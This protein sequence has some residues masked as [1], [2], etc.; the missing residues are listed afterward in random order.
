MVRQSHIRRT[1]SFWHCI[2][3]CISLFCE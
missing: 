1:V 3:L 2:S